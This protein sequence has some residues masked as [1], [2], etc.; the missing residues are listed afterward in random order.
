MSKQEFLKKISEGLSNL[1]EE[2]VNKF[3]DY[4]CEMID[5]GMEDGLSEEEAVETLGSVDDIVAS[6]MM[7]M[8]IS[9]LVKTR[10]K[11]SHTLRAWEIILIVLGFPIWGSLLCAGIA[12]VF[13]LYIALFS[14]IFALYA[15]GV[16]I[17]ICAVAGIL[18]M[19]LM[20]CTG[21]GITIALFLLG[22]GLISVGIAILIFPLLN[23]MAKG[24]IYI[25]K[26]MI[27]GIKYCIIGNKKGE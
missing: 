10:V 7:D 5:D 9:K 20:L 14:V 25:G 8:P 17:V 24:I 18:G 16:A 27:L 4:Y 15:V 19:V 1:P 6:I 21:K 13:S 12:V 22:F 11:P 2:D 26:K 23:M 3:V